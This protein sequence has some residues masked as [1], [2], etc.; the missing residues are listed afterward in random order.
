MRIEKSNRREKLRNQN[1][2]VDRKSEKNERSEQLFVTVQSRCTAL[3]GLLGSQS[4]LSES[5]LV[6]GLP[7]NELLCLQSVCV[8]AVGLVPTGRAGDG[9]RELE[10][11]ADGAKRTCGN[12]S[13]QRRDVRQLRHLTTIF[14]QLSLSL[15][16]LCTS[17]RSSQ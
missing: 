4:L 17:H 1:S 3:E 16:Y 8:C 5:V 6:L 2:E 14:L 11:P 12:E 15:Y 7:G 13:L 10:L 9:G